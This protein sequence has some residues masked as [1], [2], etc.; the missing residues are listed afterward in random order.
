[1]VGGDLCGSPIIPNAPGRRGR[2]PLVPRGRRGKEGAQ[3][4]KSQA[5]SP[6]PPQCSFCPVTNASFI[7]KAPRLQGRVAGQGPGPL[8]SA[9]RSSEGSG[10]A[11]RRGCPAFPPSASSRRSPTAGPKGWLGFPAEL[12][13][14]DLRAAPWLPRHRLG[15]RP[16]TQLSRRGLPSRWPAGAGCAHTHTHKIG[17]AHV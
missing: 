8:G 1:M 10:R 13:R 12:G 14:P 2:R 5:V 6:S 16:R 9:R 7:L 15:V 11:A 3:G 17:R 4:A